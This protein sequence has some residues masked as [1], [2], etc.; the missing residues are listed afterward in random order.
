MKNELRD[1]IGKTIVL[2]TC[3]SWIYLGRLEQVSDHSVILSN[4]DA[5]DINDT[6][7]SKEFYIYDAKTAGIKPNRESI[8][9]NLAYVVSFSRLKDIKEF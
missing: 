4:A 1:C 7:A 9:V 5:H 3:S 8:S 6:D 2:D